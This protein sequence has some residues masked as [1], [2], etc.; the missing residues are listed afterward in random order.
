M[1]AVGADLSK[2]P[3]PDE[4]G[5]LVAPLLPSFAARPQAGGAAPRDER[6]VFT[7]VA[8]VLTSGCARRHL[9]PTFG[10]PSATAHRHFTVGT[11]VGLWRRL[12]RAVLDELGAQGEADRTSAIVY[13]ASVPAKKGGPLTGRTRSIAASRAANCT[14]CPMP[15]ASRSP[16]P[17]PARTCMTVSP[18]SSLV[19]GTLAIRSRRGPRR[20]RPV[21]L[22]ADKAHFCTT[23]EPAPVTPESPLLR[24]PRTSTGHP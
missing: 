6:A 24:R 16:P 15:R 12:H 23:P 4:L 2:R 1:S 10:T 9:P 7:A 18:S 21:E 5:E 13:A 19:L 17:C 14:C 11:E 22:R 20:R 3:V 8:Y